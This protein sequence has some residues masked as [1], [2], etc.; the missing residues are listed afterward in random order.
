MTLHLPGLD[1]NFLFLEE[2]PVQVSV[3]LE[4]FM[5]R[6][7]INGDPLNP[8]DLPDGMG[9]ELL[10]PL[11]INQSGS[12]A[13]RLLLELEA[14]MRLGISQRKNLCLFTRKLLDHQKYEVLRRQGLHHPFSKAV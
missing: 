12:L 2:E 7:K 8:T 11:Q 13:E 10:T 14:S 5:I 4:R 3:V 1:Q 6:S 9:L